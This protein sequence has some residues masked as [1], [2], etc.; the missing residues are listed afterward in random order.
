[1]FINIKFK[2]SKFNIRKR[3]IIERIIMVNITILF[4]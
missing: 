4:Q 2:E 1:M 3:Y